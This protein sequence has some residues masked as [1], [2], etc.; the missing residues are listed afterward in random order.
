MQRQAVGKGAQ[1]DH[2]VVRVRVLEAGDDEVAAEVYLALKGGHVLARGADVAYAAAIGPELALDYGAVAGAEHGH[3]AGVVESYHNCYLLTG[4]MQHL[5]IRLSPQ[6]RGC[7]LQKLGAR[8][9]I[10]S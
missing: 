7:Q 3:D 2:G 10:P 1:K 9:K 5:H 4:A 6:R 8:A